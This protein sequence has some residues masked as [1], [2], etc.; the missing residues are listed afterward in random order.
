[1]REASA[2][3]ETLL[4]AMDALAQALAEKEELHEGLSVGKEGKADW[5][6]QDENVAD[7]VVGTEPPPPIFMCALV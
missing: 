4:V 6:G 7:G 3:A 1:M 2:V 5:E